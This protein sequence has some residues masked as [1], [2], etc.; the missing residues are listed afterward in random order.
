MSDFYNLS[1]E[2]GTDKVLH[3]GYHFYYPKHLERLR[4]EEFNM[5][6]IGYQ[7]GHSCRMWERY[8]PKANVFAMDIGVEGQ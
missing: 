6:E 2:F 7:D 4:D 3:H 1:V 8:F 5:L